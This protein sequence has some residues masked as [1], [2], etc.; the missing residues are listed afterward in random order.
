MI[1]EESSQQVSE[2]SKE[3]YMINTKTQPKTKGQSQLI[4]DSV[5]DL[6]LLVD[7]QEQDRN[8]DEFK[9]YDEESNYQ[10]NK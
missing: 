9:Q 7:S 10:P 5:V 6:D 4:Q 8:Y 2:E 3:E 1:A